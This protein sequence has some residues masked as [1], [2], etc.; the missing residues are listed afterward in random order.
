MQSMLHILLK[1][2]LKVELTFS[3]DGRKRKYDF[4]YYSMIDEILDANDL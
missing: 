2:Q 3:S 4:F 1:C